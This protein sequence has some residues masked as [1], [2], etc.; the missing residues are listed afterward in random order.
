MLRE[1]QPGYGHATAP[2]VCPNVLERIFAQR[3]QGVST[4]HVGEQN[5]DFDAFD[6]VYSAT[7]FFIWQK[8]AGNIEDFKIVVAFVDLV[9]SGAN[10]SIQ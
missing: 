2:P 1:K 8:L 3:L 5:E 6:A 10:Q 7:E 9:V 4:L